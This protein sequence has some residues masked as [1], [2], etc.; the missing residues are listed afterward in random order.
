ML[1]ILVLHFFPNQVAVTL[2]SVDLSV[3]MHSALCGH[4]IAVIA[5]TLRIPFLLSTQLCTVAYPVQI[6]SCTPIDVVVC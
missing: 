3:A 4:L 5:F 1:L 2:Q 6:D